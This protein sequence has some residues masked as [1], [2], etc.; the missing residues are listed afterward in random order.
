MSNTYLWELLPD[1][2]K[3]E[4]SLASCSI[5]RCVE[6]KCA[7]REQNDELR[8]EKF[9]CVDHSWNLGEVANRLV[10]DFCYD[11]QNSWGARRTTPPG[12]TGCNVGV[13]N[14]HCYFPKKHMLMIQFF[15]DNETI[16]KDACRSVRLNQSFTLQSFSDL[17]FR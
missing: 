6:T 2:S 4:R 9:R 8:E 16:A 15:G 14:F 17:L 10:C 11:N 3:H 7:K 5:N 12:N 1:C 13:F